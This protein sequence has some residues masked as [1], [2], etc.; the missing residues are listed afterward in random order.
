MRPK[1]GGW[2]WHAYGHPKFPRLKLPD[3]EGTFLSVLKNEM[4]ETEL[5]KI[6]YSNAKVILGDCF[7][8]CLSHLEILEPRNFWTANK[9][10]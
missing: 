8:I 5:L 6:I 9:F 2:S 4:N 1:Q 7:V 10:W 3:L